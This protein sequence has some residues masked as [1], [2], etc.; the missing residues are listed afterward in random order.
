MCGAKPGREKGFVG[1][2]PL[3]K[4]V[5]G[6]EASD[7]HILLIVRPA[8]QNRGY[9]LETEKGKM[10]WRKGKRKNR[11][12]GREIKGGGGVGEEGKRREKEELFS[13]GLKTVGRIK[14]RRNSF[15]S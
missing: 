12:R 2:E 11:M 8:L 15:A 3:T 5:R 7:L 10:S 4:V 6:S 1:P 13:K 9:S 14:P